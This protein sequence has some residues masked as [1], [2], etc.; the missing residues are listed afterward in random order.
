MCVWALISSNCGISRRR[1][2]GFSLLEIN[3]A[4]VTRRVCEAL[5]EMKSALKQRKYKGAEI[6][7][8]KLT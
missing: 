4:D 8:S 2:I 7:L 5:A 3:H 6:L 1:C